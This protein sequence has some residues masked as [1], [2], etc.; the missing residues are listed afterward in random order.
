MATDARSGTPSDVV[1]LTELPLPDPF[2]AGEVHDV[3]VAARLWRENRQESLHRDADAQRRAEEEERLEEAYRRGLLD[4]RAAADAEGLELL[5]GLQRALEDVSEQSVKRTRLILDEAAED[6]VA[7]AG[8]IARWAIG[9]DVST[10]PTVLLDIAV[11]ALREA[12]GV[13]G[14]VVHVHPSVGRAAARWASRFGV[15]APE[16]VEDPALPEGE[17]VVRS[18]SDGTAR[19]SIDALVARI[20]DSLSSRDPEESV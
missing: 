14:A 16:V 9:R 12:G 2:S 10:D 13:E 4:G 17:V 20:C 5:T 3:A 11:T 15:A 1:D 6:L 18:A 19:V 8:V 7:A